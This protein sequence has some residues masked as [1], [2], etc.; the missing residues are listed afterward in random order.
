MPIE[1]LPTESANAQGGEGANAKAT[2]TAS[3]A[4]N[5]SDATA[6]NTGANANTGAGTQAAQQ[7]TEA[8]HE[9]EKKFSQADVDRIVLAGENDGQPQVEDLQRQLS[10]Q[11]GR[12]RSFEAREAVEDYLNDGRNKLNVQ[13][14]N[15]K[16]I[17]K[18]VVPDLEY[19]DN[20]K[21]TNIKEAVETAKSIAPALFINK[22]AANIN[23]GQRQ[24]SPI[25]DMNALIRQS[26]G[27]G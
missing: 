14:E 21:P 26:A 5:T 3:S 24:S 2:A 11:Q 16:G 7:Q 19:D 18:I 27:V 9:P 15:I 10:E 23:Q 13:S 17:L 1:G 25:S 12:V 6:K 22:T 20:G 8:Q 4:G